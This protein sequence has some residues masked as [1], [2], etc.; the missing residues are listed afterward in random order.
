M[1]TT[2]TCPKCGAERHPGE[3]RCLVCRERLR[4]GW[5]YLAVTACWLG[6]GALLV[7]WH[8]VTLAAGAL[9][10]VLGLIARRECLDNPRLWGLRRARIAIW[11]GIGAILL[12]QLAICGRAYERALEH[13]AAEA[14]WAE[15]RE[16]V[17]DVLG[18]DRESR[19]SE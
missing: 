19:I 2:I 5:S 11:L 6:V 13:A 18:E 10:I 8:P 12:G 17:E 16:I 4:P 1:S 15:V 14:E 3:K 9:A 7:F